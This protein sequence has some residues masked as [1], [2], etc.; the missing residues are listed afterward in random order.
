M[1]RALLTTIVMSLV[2]LPHGICFCDLVHAAVPAL[3]PCHEDDDR[4]QSQNQED[5]HDKDCDCT[6]R[7]TMAPSQTTSVKQLGDSAPL[8]VLCQLD[9]IGNQ[10]R[11]GVIDPQ[12]NGTETPIPLI[13]CALRI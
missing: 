2:A 10:S 5:D 6:L 12:P 4:E 13:L 3:E 8:C 9:P 7:D 11:A 1:L